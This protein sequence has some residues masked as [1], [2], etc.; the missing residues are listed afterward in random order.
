MSDKTVTNDQDKE[1]Q[2]KKGMQEVIIRVQFN[3]QDEKSSV[4]VAMGSSNHYLNKPF[5]TDT[6]C[7]CSI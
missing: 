6:C 5:H 7:S 2:D 4:I 1:D 3:A